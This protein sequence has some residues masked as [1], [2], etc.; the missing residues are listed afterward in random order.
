M[1]NQVQGNGPYPLPPQTNQSQSVDINVVQSTPIQDLRA[2]FQAIAKAFNIT[3]ADFFVKLGDLMLSSSTFSAAAFQQRFFGLINQYSNG[4]VYTG[5]PGNEVPADLTSFPT[6]PKSAVPTVTQPIVS[7]RIPAQEAQI[8]RQD[9]QPSTIK[10]L[11]NQTVINSAIDKI[12]NTADRTNTSYTISIFLYNTIPYIAFSTLA[13]LAATAQSFAANPAQT[14]AATAAQIYGSGFNL[15]FGKYFTP[16]ELIYFAA[17]NFYTLTLKRGIT[18]K[19]LETGPSIIFNPIIVQQKSYNAILRT[20][21]PDLGGFVQN[22]LQNMA[23]SQKTATGRNSTDVTININVSTTSSTP[24]HKMIDGASQNQNKNATGGTNIIW[25][26]NNDGTN[27]DFDAMER[28]MKDY[29]G[30]NLIGCVYVWPVDSDAGSPARIPFE[31]NPRIE[32]GDMAAKYQA[33]AI[34]SRIGE[35]QSFT[36]T[37]SLTVQLST[38]YYALAEKEGDES[39]QLDYL[40]FF[41]LQQLQY[42]ELA[43]RSIVLPFFPEDQDIISG[44]RYMRPP[45]VKVIMGN[46][47]HAEDSDTSTEPYYNLLRYP[48][49]VIGPNRFANINGVRFRN[50]RTFICTSVKID[51]NFDIYNIFHDNTS[52]IKDTHGYEVSM[53]LTEVSPSY[54]DSLPSF[55]DFFLNSGAITV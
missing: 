38:V 47:Q 20:G 30:L 42:I 4:V 25:G 28:K 45:V 34:L 27:L 43:Y 52:G 13:G 17:A 14:L 3:A 24:I 32:E 8:A 18:I 49:K 54:V 26:Q 53:S 10:S 46:Y 1:A 5:Q 35:L 40:S 55:K 23:I 22:Y 36:G 19:D 51:K 39:P 7:P 31:F 6:N 11:A 15:D 12:F 37:G 33:Q 41:N 21:T 16:D 2:T 9:I 48:D 44:Y 29:R 50:F